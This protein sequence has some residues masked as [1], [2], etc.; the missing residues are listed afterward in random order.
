M[1][2]AAHFGS[3]ARSG[4]R[5][6]CFTSTDRIE[7]PNTP[8]CFS[9]APGMPE[10]VRTALFVSDLQPHHKP[11][12]SAFRFLRYSEPNPAL[13]TFALVHAAGRAGSDQHVFLDLR[14]TVFRI[15]NF[16]DQARQA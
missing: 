1:D 12:L 3:P 2:F 9:A 11:C 14:D 5:K 15:G 4:R 16:R 7:A 6:K 13:L 10:L 8:N